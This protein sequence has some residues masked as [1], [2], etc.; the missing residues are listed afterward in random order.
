M[1][2]LPVYLRGEEDDGAL[3]SSIIQQL[4]KREQVGCDD[5]SHRIQW[6]KGWLSQY[7]KK[8]GVLIVVWDFRKL[9]GGSIGKIFWK[10]ST[11]SSRY[12]LFALFI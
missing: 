12:K 4:G 5:T 1:N 2:L 8:I 11:K 6:L 10:K 3:F 9:M 7:K